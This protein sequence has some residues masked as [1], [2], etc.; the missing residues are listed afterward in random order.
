MCGIVFEKMKGPS[1]TERVFWQ[2]QPSE[3][4]F[5]KVVMRGSAKF[6]IKHLCQKGDTIAQV[7]A[8]GFCEI[9]KNIFLT[10]HHLT[11]AS[12]YSSI[13]SSVGRF[14]KRNGKL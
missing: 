8:C 11:T 2:K 9:C 7:F 14:N 10:E 4:F 1:G 5:K 6:T 13:N 3:C 12:D